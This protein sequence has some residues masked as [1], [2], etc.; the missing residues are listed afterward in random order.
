MIDWKYINKFIGIPFKLG[1]RDKNGIDCIGLVWKYLHEQDYKVELHKNCTAEWIKNAN[2]SEW[3]ELVK[4]YGE[5]IEVNQLQEND[6]LYFAWKGEIHAGI[7][8]GYNKYLHISSKTSSRLS[9]LNEAAKKHI[10]AIM[11]PSKTQK[12]ILPPAEIG[13]AHV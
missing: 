1:G 2:F 9:R 8:I 13:R 10:I 12:K 3:I 6:I 5:P 4:S 7:Y 11:R